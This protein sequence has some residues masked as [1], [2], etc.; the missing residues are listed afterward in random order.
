[1]SGPFKTI[2]KDSIITWSFWL[3]IVFI[4]A[5]IALVTIAFVHLPPVIPLYNKMSWG[6]ERLGRTYEIV[7][8]LS[9]P[10]VFFIGNLFFGKYMHDKVPL[11]SRFLSLTAL[12]LSIF[13]FIF[14]IKMILVVI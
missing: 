11:L 9:L 2:F 1:M 12:S 4:V 6:Y 10:L 8:P 7:F 14:M 5:S 3:T 13:T